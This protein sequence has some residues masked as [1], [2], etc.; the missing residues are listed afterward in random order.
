[1]KPRSFSRRYGFDPNQPTGPIVDDAPEWI[2]VDYINQV[3]SPI[4]FVDM[5]DRYKNTENAPLGIKALHESFCSLLREETAYTYND[6]WYCWDE[7]AGHLRSCAW[8]QFYDFVELA[9]RSLKEA[10]AQHALDD[11]WL[12]EFGFKTYKDRV[13]ELFAHENVVW[14]LSNESQLQRRIPEVLGKR[15]ENTEQRLA[16]QFEPAREHYRKALRYLQEHPLDPENSIKETVSS[17]ES[18]ARALFPRATTLGAAVKE[19]RRAQTVP[20]G[21]LA[22]VEKLYAFASDEPAVRHGASVSSRVVRE[23]AEL[24]FHVGVALIRYLIDRSSGE[25]ERK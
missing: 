6:S 16:S 20:P 7:L 18:V 22:L 12:A 17:L 2:R 8:Y 24:C 11:D 15:A 10:E 5:D 3:L 25:A 19:M 21:L 14:R 9:G 4:T 13:N 23:D 1:M